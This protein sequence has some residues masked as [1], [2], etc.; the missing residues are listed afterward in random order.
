M[1]DLEKKPS[2][3]THRRFLINI[4]TSAEAGGAGIYSCFFDAEQGTLSDPQLAVE[5]T[6]PLF[7]A[8]HPNGRL[9]YAVGD[10]RLSEDKK[11][12]NVWAF[13]ITAD[14][15]KLTFL[16]KVPSGGSVP[17]HITIDRTGTFALIANYSSG[18]VAVFP[19]QKDGQLTDMTALIQHS[20]SSLDLSR[21]KEP[22]PHSI[23]PTA[24][25]RFALVADL[26]LDKLLIYR[27]NS[28]GGSLTPNFPAFAALKPGSGPRH[29]AFTHDGRYV[30]VINELANTVTAFAYD[31]SS[32]VLSEIQTIITIPETYSNETYASEIKIHPSGNYL[33][34]ANRGH[35]SIAAFGINRHTGMLTLIEIYPCGGRW[36]RH[37]SIDPTGQWLLVANER[38]DTIAVFGIDIGNGKLTGMDSGISLPSPVCLQFLYDYKIR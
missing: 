23:T 21:Q 20:G 1:S 13:S 25:N 6:S 2:A 29:I 32:A 22:H 31:S 37:F 8:V 18:S 7:L 3:S 28:E 15:G 36:P 5:V 38:S 24:D 26:G 10:S 14:T 35:D 12:P 30:Y 17:C 16:N 9:L 27:F 34:G 19:I 4:G 33:Y 11:S